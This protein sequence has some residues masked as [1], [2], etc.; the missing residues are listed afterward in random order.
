V[1]TD[2]LER[3]LHEEHLHRRGE[4]ADV[5]DVQPGLEH[6]PVRQA[7]AAELG[8]DQ[9][10]VGVEL[11]VDALV[12]PL[13]LA[14]RPADLALHVGKRPRVPADPDDPRPQEL[15]L[16][17]QLRF[18]QLID[19]LPVGPVAEVGLDPP[20]DEGA[21]ERALPALRDEGDRPES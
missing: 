2:P 15:V 5:H 4:G 9:L 16:L 7:R 21:G 10:E 18:E 1:G 13:G 3:R 8:D 12:D 11:G 6:D 20:G 19:E 17:S 14:E